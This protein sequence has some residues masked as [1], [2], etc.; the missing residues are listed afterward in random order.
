[1]IQ[2][3]LRDTVKETVENAVNLI[4]TSVA[5]YNPRIVALSECFITSY[6]PPTF[7]KVAESIHTGF[8]CTALRDVA[9]ELKI[10]VIGGVIELDE[11]DANNVYNT[12]VVWD[13]NGELVARHRKVSNSVSQ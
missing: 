8:T 2:T 3:D 10:Y 12:A 4:R 1:M 11:V 7:Q 6:D 5:Q 9:K 13:P